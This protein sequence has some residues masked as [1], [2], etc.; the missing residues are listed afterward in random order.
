VLSKCFGAG[1][2]YPVR[3][4]DGMIATDPKM[5]NPRADSFSLYMGYV[6]DMILRGLLPKARLIKNTIH[7]VLP[8]YN[9]AQSEN[10]KKLT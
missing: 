1:I 4:K 7:K 3:T 6:G 10:I 2:A 9:T 8:Q 5:S